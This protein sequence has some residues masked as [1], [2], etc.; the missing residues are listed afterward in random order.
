[1]GKIHDFLI[2]LPKGEAVYNELY[3]LIIFKRNFEA[4]Q[5][6]KK[7]SGEAI[8]ELESIDTSKKHIYFVGVPMHLNMGDQAQKYCIDMW[9]KNNYPDYD[10]EHFFTWPFYN[11]SFRKKLRKTIQPQ[12]IIVIQSGY[13]TTSWHFDH[14]MHRFIVKNFKGNPVL[15]MPQTVLFSRKRDAKK[16][17]AIYGQHK[18]LLFLARDKISYESAKEYFKGT[19]VECFPDIVTTL[20]GDF[21]YN[22][23][24]ERKGVLLCVRND[25]EKLYSSYVIESLSKRFRDEGYECKISDTNSTLP[26]K[27]LQEKFED[28]LKKQIEEFAGYKLIITDRYHGTIFSL[29][30][31][32]PVIVLSTNDHKVKTGTEWF[33]GVYEGS[34]FNAD[35][36][37]EAFNIAIKVLNSDK[38]LD[39]HKYFKEYYNQLYKLFLKVMDSNKKQQQSDI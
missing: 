8:E 5:K 37:D 33:R 10:I 3:S 18:K 19:K 7:M 28:E 25:G 13:C 20:I 24:K 34:Y 4:R 9:L 1:M 17:A 29:I 23:P 27:E 26:L 14:Y 30:A 22:A 31:N 6:I 2:K 16:T 38:D 32:T 36:I 15:I 11:S 21:K 35:G 39:N 12:D